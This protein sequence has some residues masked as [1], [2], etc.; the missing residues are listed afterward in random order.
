MSRLERIALGF[1]ELRAV[2]RV[3]PIVPRLLPSSTWNVSRLLD[4]HVKRRP[5]AIALIFEGRRF[6]WRWKMTNHSRHCTAKRK[7]RPCYSR[8][9]PH[10]QPAR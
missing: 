10:R 3:L 6:T 4:L 5:G 8:W 7:N 2:A 9:N 1:Q